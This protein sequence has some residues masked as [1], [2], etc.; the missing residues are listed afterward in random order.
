MKCK[1]GTEKPKVTGGDRLD[2]Q[3]TLVDLILNILT[4]RGGSSPSTVV[5]VVEDGVTESRPCLKPSRTISAEII[6]AQFLPR[7]T[8]PIPRQYPNAEWDEFQG[9]EGSH[10]NSTRLLDFDL[11]LWVEKPIL[12]LDNLQEVKIEK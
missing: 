3:R 7:A 11:A 9:L 2:Y 6:S 1:L 5:I 10:S 12:T 8:R 4:S